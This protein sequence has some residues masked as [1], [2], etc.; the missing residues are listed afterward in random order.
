MKK[1]LASLLAIT[2]AFAFTACSLPG[3]DDDDDSSSKKS[4][5]DTS[6]SV[7]E[8]SEEDS[9]DDESSKADDTSSAA[10]VDESSVAEDEESSVVEESSAD[11]SSEAEKPA[12]N[13]NFQGDGYT[14]NIDS[15]KWNDISSS[16]A[17]VDCAFSYVGDTSNTNYA[18]ANF[19]VISQKGASG[20]TPNDY[21][22]VVKKKYDTMGYKI[23][24]DEAITFN[25]Y[26]AYK[27]EISMEQSGLTMNMNQIV[28]VDND[29]LYVISF[30]SEASVFSTL[31]PEFDSVLS[32]FAIS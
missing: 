19:N 29:T 32:T 8:S 25:G 17:G 13:G 15:A 3:S 20:I 9:N 5:K 27:I 10:E 11:D 21:M 26:D 18:T 1:L 4:K 24:K 28:I 12:A 23:T 14:L 30:G 16:V 2:M 6:S 22:Q 31:K 7:V